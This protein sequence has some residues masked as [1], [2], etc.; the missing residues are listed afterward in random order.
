MAEV[1]DIQGIHRIRLMPRDDVERDFPM[2]T[3]Q[4]YDLS[5]EDFNY[6]CLAFALGDYSHWWEPPMG[7]EQYWPPGFDEDASVQTVEAI[8][9]VSG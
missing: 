6:N 8:T 7:P 5:D 9:L 1:G 3:G 2:L 4:Q